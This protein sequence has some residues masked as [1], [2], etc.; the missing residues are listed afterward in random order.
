MVAANANSPEDA[1]A[2]VV[3]VGVKKGTKRTQKR[4]AALADAVLFP[5]DVQTSKLQAY[6]TLG[7]MM[8]NVEPSTG[9][10]PMPMP[11][12]QATR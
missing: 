4:D 12:P 10:K 3:W 8:A 6:N 2:C 11:R 9:G 1:N 7:W 5:G